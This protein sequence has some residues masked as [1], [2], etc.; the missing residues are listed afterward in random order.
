MQLLDDDFKKL[1]TTKRASTRALRPGRTHGHGRQNVPTTQ[2]L[3]QPRKSHRPSESKR[4][5][6]RQSV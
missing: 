5:L 6:D 4:R 1:A 3:L 2:R